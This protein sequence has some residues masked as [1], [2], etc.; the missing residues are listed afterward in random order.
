MDEICKVKAAFICVY[1]TFQFEVM[2]FGLTNS[3]ATPP[4]MVDRTLLNVAKVRC[5]VDDVV[6]FS[7]KTVEHAIHLANVFRILVKMGRG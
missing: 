3:Q 5:Y 1:G 6:I 7:K 4:K 2:T